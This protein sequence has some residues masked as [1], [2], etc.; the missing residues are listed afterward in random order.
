MPQHFSGQYP[1]T[2]M[3]RARAQESTRRLARET[4]LGVDDLIY[5]LF[6]T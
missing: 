4:R 1:A 5:P 3:R 6:I 2:R